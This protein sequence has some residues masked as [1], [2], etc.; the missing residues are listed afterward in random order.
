LQRVSAQ[1]IVG[2][3]LWEVEEW[4]GVRIDQ[5]MNFLVDFADEEVKEGGQRDIYIVENDQ[6]N[7][8]QTTTERSSGR[9]DFTIPLQLQH[10]AVK[11]AFVPS[12]DVEAAVR[13]GA[14]D[15]GVFG[16]K[17]MVTEDEA[18][19]LVDRL[20][21][22]LRNLASGGQIEVTQE[23]GKVSP[24]D[25][26]KSDAAGA[27]TA[28]EEQDEEKPAPLRSG[29]RRATRF[30]WPRPVSVLLGRS[31]LRKVG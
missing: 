19:G 29:P 3:G 10:N 4:T 13:N 9:D 17:S 31:D 6:S 15:I 14:L 1:D 16:P 18:D 7:K 23:E 21:D 28:G 25:G 5:F 26:M 12:I 22:V 11:H 30:V 8:G 24:E 2:T 20:C 27:S